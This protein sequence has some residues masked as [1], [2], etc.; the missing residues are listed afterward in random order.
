MSIA[1]NKDDFQNKV[2]HSIQKSDFL[3]WAYTK[4]FKSLFLDL[5]GIS[6]S[7]Y[8]SFIP[9]QKELAQKMLDGMHPMSPR[10]AGSVQEFEISPLD[11]DLMGEISAPTLIF[12]A[13]DDS[14]VNYGHAEYANRYIIQSKLIS[15]ETGGH[16]LITQMGNILCILPHRYPL[17]KRDSGSV[18]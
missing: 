12:H 5:I 18:D 2:I 16:G 1:P 7:V 10:R 11:G 14:L 3:Y 15:F 6:P 8:K 13:R 17:P 4:L 9:E